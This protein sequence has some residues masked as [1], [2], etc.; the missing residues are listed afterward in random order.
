VHVYYV[1]TQILSSGKSCVAMRTL[2]EFVL[3]LT[4]G[5]RFDVC[6][7]HLNVHQDLLDVF[8][9]FILTRNAEFLSEHGGSCLIEQVDLLDEVL[10]NLHVGEGGGRGGV[11]EGGAVGEEHV[12]GVGQ[13]G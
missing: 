8:S 3:S 12:G 4:P 2:V 10:V 7:V 1:V 13:G 9:C 11:E 6:H 5:V